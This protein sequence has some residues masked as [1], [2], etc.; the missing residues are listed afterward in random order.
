MENGHGSTTNTHPKATSLRKHWN[1]S[2]C[3]FPP[4]LSLKHEN[5]SLEKLGAASVRPEKQ[6]ESSRSQSCDSNYRI[7]IVDIK[8]SCLPTLPVFRFLYVWI[9]KSCQLLS[10]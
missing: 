4:E 2:F 9:Q 5:N 3:V 1:Q 8:Q 10:L 7:A 6:L